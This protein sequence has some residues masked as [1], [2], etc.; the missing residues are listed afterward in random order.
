MPSPEPGPARRLGGDGPDD[1]LV[2]AAHRFGPQPA[3]RL[4]DR[5]FARDLD[6]G[7]RIEQPLHSFQQASQDFTRGRVHVERQGDHVVD[8]HM[9]RKIALADAGFAGRPQHRLY[10]VPPKRPGDHSQAD[11][12]RQ[13]TAR[14]QPRNR[15]RH[16]SFPL[17]H[18]ETC[19]HNLNVTL[20]ERYWI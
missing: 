2:Q 16:H 17:K 12:V 15:P 7:R 4:R 8:H 14:R 13:P 18:A 10:L 1:R 6:R 5:R 19:Q 3:A 11:V 20:N 9:G